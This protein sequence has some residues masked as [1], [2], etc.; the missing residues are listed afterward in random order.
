MIHFDLNKRRL[1]VYP[2]RPILACIA[3]TIVI[4]VVLGIGGSRGDITG[5]HLAAMAVAFGACIFW[6]LWAFRSVRRVG[7]LVEIR[8]LFT[9]QRLAADQLIAFVDSE[10]SHDPKYG[11]SKTIYPVGLE[12]AGERVVLDTSADPMVSRKRAAQIRQVLG[13]AFDPASQGGA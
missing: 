10:T 13:L 11:T 12:G 8:N 5:L 3:V 2:R 9:V 1:T 6:L 4:A 7:E